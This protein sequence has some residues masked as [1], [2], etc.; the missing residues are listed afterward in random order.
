[1]SWNLFE[2]NF[3]KMALFEQTILISVVSAC[4]ERKLDFNFVLILS[5][6]VNFKRGESTPLTS[7]TYIFVL[8]I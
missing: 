5:E 1:M 7:P 2:L 4:S 8:V 3:D 6:F